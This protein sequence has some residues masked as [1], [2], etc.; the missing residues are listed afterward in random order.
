MWSHALKGDEETRWNMRN[1]DRTTTR[2]AKIQHEESPLF[3]AVQWI[4]GFAFV[5]RVF[6]TT[7]PET[8]INQ[9]FWAT[10]KHISLIEYF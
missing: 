7:L 1:N 8:R 2:T 3:I 6:I 9:G 4:A 5:V 10:G